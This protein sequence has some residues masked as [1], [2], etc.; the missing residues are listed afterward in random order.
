MTSSASPIKSRWWYVF[1][2]LLGVIGGVVSW[3]A[4]KSFDSKLAKNCLV[5]G[6]ILGTVETLLLIGFL[7]TSDS[8]N[9]ATQIGSI[10][11]TGDFGIRFKINTP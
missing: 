8:L 2:I 9:L 5:L 3:L 11:E 6:I 1:P 10:S 7:I 4:L